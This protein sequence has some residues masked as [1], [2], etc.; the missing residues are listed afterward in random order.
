[1]SRLTE[2]ILSEALQDRFPPETVSPAVVW[3]YVVFRG[4]ADGAMQTNAI[5][6]DFRKGIDGNGL[7]D[8][9]AVAAAELFRPGKTYPA[10]RPHFC[11]PCAE[12]ITVTLCLRWQI[13]AEEIADFF[14]ERNF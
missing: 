13:L 8:K 14:P 6:A 10:A 1:M 2:D 11:E 5:D 12:K 7:L 4:E 9:T 3:L